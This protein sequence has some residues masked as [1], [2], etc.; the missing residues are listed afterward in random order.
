MLSLCINSFTCFLVSS[1][2]STV[3]IN[4]KSHSRHIVT[5]SIY[6]LWYHWMNV[7]LSLDNGT[8]AYTLV[9]VSND[10]VVSVSDQRLNATLQ[11]G[12]GTDEPDNVSFVFEFPEE[13]C[14]LEGSYTCQFKMVEN[15][16]TKFAVLAVF[17]EGICQTFYAK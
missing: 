7:Y 6:K 11:K 14:D 2:F 5:C 16:N 9:N 12:G 4:A 10:G 3:T 17:V 8:K 15:L 13:A 1:I